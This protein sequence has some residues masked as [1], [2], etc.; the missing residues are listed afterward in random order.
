MIHCYITNSQTLG[1]VD[2]LLECVERQLRNGVE[3]IQIREKHLSARALTS[4]VRRALALPNPLGSEILVNTR[5]DVAVICGARG[6]HLPST[7]ISPRDAKRAAPAGFRAGVSCHTID[8]L[9]RAEDDGAD[10]AVFSPVFKPLSK[11]YEG[12]C[13]G[14]DGLAQGCRAV[15]IPVLALGGITWASADQCQAAGAAGVA[16]ITLFQQ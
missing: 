4:L 10:Y 14:L 13:L 6:V 12:A 7:S 11:S 15:R 8:E 2:A 1:G 9:K 3:M 16:G 5:T